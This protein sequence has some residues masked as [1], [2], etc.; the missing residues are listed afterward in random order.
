MPSP[1]RPSA[2]G[3]PRRLAWQIVDG[4]A[5]PDALALYRQIVADGWRFPALALTF[6][7]SGH[8]RSSQARPGHS[9]ERRRRRCLMGHPASG[10]INL[11]LGDAYLEAA[12]GLDDSDRTTRFE[13]QFASGRL[14]TITKSAILS[15]RRP[16]R[17]G[18]S[19]EK[20]RGHNGFAAH[21]N[22][23]KSRVS[24]TITALARSSESYAG[25][26]DRPYAGKA[27]GHSFA[28]RVGESRR[29]LRA[30]AGFSRERAHDMTIWVPRSRKHGPKSVS[31]RTG[32]FGKQRDP[33]PAAT[34]SLGRRPAG[35]PRRNGAHRI[36]LEVRG[37]FSS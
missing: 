6:E 34:I 13:K 10:L 25:T 21:A 36:R 9:E 32:R 33:I 8:G 1:T 27:S 19:E 30:E 4:L 20:A 12:L 15:E 5:Q 35:S 26:L 18:R 14:H 7:Q 2:R 31:T 3:R 37:P 24:G 28:P 22:S 17:L 23:E 16:R 29:N 11:V